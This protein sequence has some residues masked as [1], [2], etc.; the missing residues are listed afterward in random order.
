MKTATLAALILAAASVPARAQVDLSGEWAARFHEDQLERIPGPEVGDYSGIPIND[1][2]RLRADS[3]DA[4]LLTL[5]EEQCIPH[6]ATY[7]LRGP[8]DLRISQDIDPVTQQVRAI[9]IYGTFGRATR[10]IW[11]D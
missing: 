1:D 9:I 3:W 2:L 6:P 10:V 7:S 4:S 5:L 11:M 8:A